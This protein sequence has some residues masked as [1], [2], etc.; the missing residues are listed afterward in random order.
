MREAL[1]SGRAEG[2]GR[3]RAA[4]LGALGLALAV[5]SGCGLAGKDKK[6]FGEDCTKAADCESGECATYGSVCSKTC[7]YDSECGSGYVCR[8]RDDGPGSV[9]SKA[10]GQAPNG[11][12]MVPAECDHGHCLKRVGQ[13]DQAG[14]CSLPC[15]T[16]ND[17]PAGMKVCESISD[18]GGTRYC[19][20]G[21]ESP[22][23]ERPKF[24][25]APRPTTRPGTTTT[26][27]TA[28]TTTSTKTPPPAGGLGDVELGGK[29]D[30]GT[31]KSDAGTGTPDA[32]TKS[33]AGTPKPD[34]GTPKP[35]AGTGSGGLGGLGDLGTPTKK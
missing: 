6:K 22:T 16:A 33:D 13:Q 5:G 9:C 8:V 27:T 24:T 17:C 26:A 25:P 31:P 3:A 19:L 35:D 2:R 20:P 1:R 10:Q 30:A 34:A 11:T 12:C 15:Q 28:T 29:P 14:F 7:T 32:G 21:G 18:S 23:A 4:L